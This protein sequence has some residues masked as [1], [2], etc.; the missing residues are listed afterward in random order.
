MA[1]TASFTT[2]H[3]SIPKPTRT[4]I[5]SHRSCKAREIHKRED[6]ARETGSFRAAHVGS[7]GGRVFPNFPLRLLPVLN[8]S[9][10]LVVEFVSS[11]GDLRR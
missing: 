8:S 3:D 5:C 10:S 1:F 9:T 2:R 11:L 7:L 4:R 6:C